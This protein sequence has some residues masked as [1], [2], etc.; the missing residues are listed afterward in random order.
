[1]RPGQGSVG[2]PN[3]HPGYP[4]SRWRRWQGT[5]VI[6]PIHPPLDQL[7]QGGCDGAAPPTAN[8]SI[9][10]EARPRPGLGAR[11][12]GA[13]PGSLLYGAIVTAAVFV[14]TGRAGES[15]AQVVGIW[16]FVIGTYYLAHV[17]VHA[18]ESQFEGDTRHLLRR[19]I[20]AAKDQVGVLE[21]GLPAMGVFV[22]ASIWFQEIS[23][24]KL[25]LY[26]TVVLLAVFG[27]VGSRHAERTVSASLGEAFG[28]SLLGVLMVLAKSLLH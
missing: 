26:F 21:G 4:A 11:L 14:A 3:H 13:H 16:A 12:S 5:A 25:A 18:A 7:P 17:Y 24:E 1:M 8:L 27:Y 10:E 22:L 6:S 19:S 2:R 23:A 9:V 28:A 15:V 20:Y